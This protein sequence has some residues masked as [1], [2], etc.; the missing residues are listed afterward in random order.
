MIHGRTAHVI[1]P[2]AAPSSGGNWQLLVNAHPTAADQEIAFRLLENGQRNH[3]CDHR[4]QCAASSS[5]TAKSA[6]S[7]TGPL[8]NHWQNNMKI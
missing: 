5:K 1:Q 3:I 7:G 4:H 2:G 8:E 6:Q